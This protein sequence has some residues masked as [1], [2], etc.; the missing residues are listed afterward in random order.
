[1]KKVKPAEE[2]RQSVRFRILS[3]IKHANGSNVATF[4]VTNIRNVSRGGLAFFTGQELRDGAV[5]ELIFLP[6]NRK[7]PVEA[8]GKVVRCPRVIK[9][10]EVFDVGVQFLDISEDAKLA[11]LELEGFFLEAQKKAR[12]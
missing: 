5:L 11:I 4:E 3:I 6:P 1:V 2:R 8:R 12:S 9:D 7:K 10:K